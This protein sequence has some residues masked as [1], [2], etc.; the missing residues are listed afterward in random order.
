MKPLSAFAALL[1]AMTFVA[2]EASQSC[3]GMDRTV[4]AAMTSLPP[5]GPDC[6]DAADHLGAGMGVGCAFA[7]HCALLCGVTAP[8]GPDSVF[9]AQFVAL[10]F[11]T[12]AEQMTGSQQKPEA[13]PPRPLLL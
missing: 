6:H 8:A 4:A 10:Q 12:S 13:P 11:F 2:A 3:A 7:A 5:G 9:A 1:L